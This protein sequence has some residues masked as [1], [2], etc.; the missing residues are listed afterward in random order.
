M[1]S[2]EVNEIIKALQEWNKT[3]YE[4]PKAPSPKAYEKQVFEE[5]MEE[6]RYWT[7]E[8]TGQ[9]YMLDG[10]VCVPAETF[11]QGQIEARLDKNASNGI[12][13]EVLGHIKRNTFV[14]RKMFDKDPYLVNVSNGLIDVIQGKFFKHSPNSQYLSLVQLPVTYDRDAS[15]PKFIKFLSEIVEPADR[16]IIMQMIGY[17]LLR[18]N[19][20]H[21]A[22]MLYGSGANGKSVLIS[23]IRKLLGEEN[24]SSIPLQYFSFHRFAAAELYKKMLN[25]FADIPKKELTDTGIF[26]ALVAGDE[27]IAERKGQQPFSFTNYAKL[28]FS[29]NQLP[30]TEDDTEGFW[31]RWIIVEF[32]NSFD[33]AKNVNLVSELTT[34]KELSGIFNLAS[35]ALRYLIHE[36]GFEYNS[37]EMI[38]RKYKN[39]DN[40]FDQFLVETC[41]LKPYD[42]TVRSKSLDIY[43]AYV[44]FCLDRKTGYYNIENFG[45]K[46]A[47]YGIL[48]KRMRSGPERA[49]VYIGITLKQVVNQSSL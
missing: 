10:G 44:R 36:G 6:G 42:G 41:V 20:F 49:N 2:G 35:R 7:M 37:P 28:I 40:I 17:C 43:T 18:D 34:D 11:L 25:T 19:R 27:M 38:K 13:R 33:E 15:P 24:C 45:K 32:P 48:K 46:L 31:R 5:I 22:F 21:K 39:M 3:K 9:I 16:S 30:E 12:V 29:A 1:G 4:Q 14:S 26:K 47:D 23:V 8:D